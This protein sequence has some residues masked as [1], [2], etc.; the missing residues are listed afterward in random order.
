MEQAL[1]K[2]KK[3]QKRPAKGKAPA[4]TGKKAAFV[5]LLRGINVGGKQTVPMEMLTEVFEGAGCG[6]V[7]TYIQS[8]NVV[9]SAP[10]ATVADMAKGISK[11]LG[12]RLGFE[13]PVVVRSAKELVG[14]VKS[15]PFAEALPGT[16][17]VAFLADEPAKK[18]LA[19]LDPN[20][21]PG[22]TFEVRGREVYLHC[23]NGV[24]RSKLTNAY[25]DVKL[26][27]VS[28]ARNWRTVE[29]LLAMVQ[30]G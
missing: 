3:V 4:R 29:A 21:S 17:H 15:N 22:D 14:I 27:T 1:A 7:R 5:A 28:T 25:F 2:A 13:P 19:D 30:E 20:R 6:N 12:K 23:P 9:F 18:R 26:G 11:E 8:G 10:A 24:A 16:V